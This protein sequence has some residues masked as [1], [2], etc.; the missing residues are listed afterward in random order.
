V[1][2]NILEHSLQADTFTTISQHIYYLGEG[3]EQGIIDKTFSAN[4]VKIS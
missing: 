3:G 2:S 1:K 4:F